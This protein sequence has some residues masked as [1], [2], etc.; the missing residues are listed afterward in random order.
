V[1]WISRTTWRLSQF[2]F[3][4]LDLTSAVRCFAELSVPVPHHAV[5]PTLSRIV[6]RPCKADVSQNGHRQAASSVVG[7][8][9]QSGHDILAV[10]LG[11]VA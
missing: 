10:Q 11:R 1:V 5:T 8:A 3:S 4:C 6:D 2:I 9:H 7:L